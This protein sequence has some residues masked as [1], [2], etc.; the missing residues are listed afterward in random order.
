MLNRAMSEVLYKSAQNPFLDEQLRVIDEELKALPYTTLVNTREELTLFCLNLYKSMLNTVD[1]KDLETRSAIL[2]A[3]AQNQLKLGSDL[4]LA[5]QCL[6]EASELR[7]HESP[8]VKF[9]IAE[10]LLRIGED[11][12]TVTRKY[13]HEAV[14][15]LQHRQRTSSENFDLVWMYE[16]YARGMM[17]I[18]DST[19]EPNDIKESVHTMRDSLI[20]QRQVVVDRED[21]TL[22]VPQ[23][24]LQAKTLIL[25]G[26][27]KEGGQC[28]MDA[29]EILRK[30]F[31]HHRIQ[32][33]TF[34]EGMG[35]VASLSDRPQ[36]KIFIEVARIALQNL[37]SMNRAEVAETECIS[38]MKRVFSERSMTEFNSR[39]TREALLQFMLDDPDLLR[40]ERA[41]TPAFGRVIQLFEN[42][43][44]QHRWNRRL[45][46]FMLN[47]WLM[48][49]PA[50]L[51][52]VDKLNLFAKPDE[53]LT[54]GVLTNVTQSSHEEFVKCDTLRGVASLYLQAGMTIM[55]SEVALT[56]GTQL[57]ETGLY[58]LRKAHK[59]SPDSTIFWALTSYTTVLL[60][61]GHRGRARECASS[62]IQLLNRSS[63][64]AYNLM[65]RLIINLGNVMQQIDSTG[66]FIEIVREARVL[67]DKT[68]LVSEKLVLLEME[69]WS[70]LLRKDKQ[71]TL[72]IIE[73]LKAYS[74]DPRI[75]NNTAL[76][77]LILH[78][79]QATQHA[80]LTKLQQA[81]VLS[82]DPHERRIV[83]G[84]VRFGMSMIKRPTPKQLE[85][86]DVN[87]LD[88]YVNETSEWLMDS[89]NPNLCLFPA[90]NEFKDK[91][92]RAVVDSEMVPLFL[93]VTNDQWL[94][95]RMCLITRESRLEQST[96]NV[97][98]TPEPPKPVILFGFRNNT[99]LVMKNV[100][101]QI[102]LRH[103]FPLESRSLAERN[104]TRLKEAVRHPNILNALMASKHRDHSIDVDME[105]CDAWSLTNLIP[106]I[107]PAWRPIVAASVARQALQ[108]IVY[109][110]LLYPNL[111]FR[112]ISPRY[113]YVCRDGSVKLDL[114]DLIEKDLLG[115]NLDYFLESPYTAPE[116]RYTIES[117]RNS[118]TCDVWS[119]GVL[120]V[121]IMTGH[122]L[123]PPYRVSDR[124]VPGEDE[125]AMIEY[126]DDVSAF[127][128]LI[129]VSDDD[130]WREYIPNDYLR[131]LARR[132]LQLRNDKRISSVSA[133]ATT[134][135]L[136][137]VAASSAP[138]YT[139]DP[140]QEVYL[141]PPTELVRP[142]DT[143]AF[144]PEQARL[145]KLRD[146]TRSSSFIDTGNTQPPAQ[147]GKEILFTESPLLALGENIIPHPWSFDRD[148]AFDVPREDLIQRGLKIDA[149]G[150]RF[151]AVFAGY[152]QENLYSIPAE[153][154]GQRE[155]Q[156]ALN[157]SS[158]RR[159]C[160]N[161]IASFEKLIRTE[162]QAW[163][164]SRVISGIGRASDRIMMEILSKRTQNAR[165][166]MELAIKSAMDDERLE[167]LLDDLTLP[168]E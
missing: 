43:R 112:H 137:G 104:V 58:M 133:L 154:G 31:A 42:C 119:V 115:T 32:E 164:E 67:I 28:F 78:D 167:L 10:V 124:R 168:T 15:L 123:Q 106:R 79:D 127:E 52:I 49:Y 24:L 25:A 46:L 29:L 142:L 68:T 99:V 96:T 156:T 102:I 134:Y 103:I 153:T 16:Q 72:N 92:E 13:I 111:R 166:G 85:F 41:D 39:G 108:A 121:A 160:V 144:S 98:A 55:L 26:S 12:K 125:D 47:Q 7:A 84:N 70:C 62:A 51:S 65:S 81:F 80:A 71:G 40:F 11:R 93:P 155:L 1:D 17:E 73:K 36:Q 132:M 48:K 91:V 165:L 20:L 22:V 45:E 53:L 148:S 66:S 131:Y 63:P 157:V 100:E 139:R 138:T 77:E 128:T 140:E 97:F 19:A 135:A 83:R 37:F 118:M 82:T 59:E 107:P 76:V 74:S 88:V 54:N 150:P 2:I 130:L 94:K 145:I 56:L 23:I 89:I 109:L 158:T 136:G 14:Q 69:L 110:D 9:M 114:P 151:R 129:T 159:T 105:Y 3:I 161:A 86:Q 60:R 4:K 87:P 27:T 35:L 95:S 57:A 21:V 90:L 141:R 162:H 61:I 34:L 143:S 18:A 113:V 122:T 163:K 50:T 75:M 33:F 44:V 116:S 5:L 147:L 38:H 120:I 6:T 146:E 30:V 126:S 8:D 149:T 117:F 64:S 152:S 101:G